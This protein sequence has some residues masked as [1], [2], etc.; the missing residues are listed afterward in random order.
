[1]V[2]G[3]TGGWRA[4]H[5]RKA[6]PVSLGTLGHFWPRFFKL[7][8]VAGGITLQKLDGVRAGHSEKALVAQLVGRRHLVNL[9]NF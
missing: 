9:K 4:K 1:M 7:R 3:Q 6:T 2:G 5:D 8:Q